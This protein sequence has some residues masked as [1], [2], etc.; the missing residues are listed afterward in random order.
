MRILG[1]RPVVKGECN[2]LGEGESSLLSKNMRPIRYIKDD[3]GKKA[4]LYRSFIL[5]AKQY[6]IDKNIVSVDQNLVL[7]AYKTGRDIL[8]YIG[9]EKRFYCFTTDSIITSCFKTK[10]GRDT[11]LEFPIDLGTVEYA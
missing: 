8:V 4:I 10:R 6:V 1:D 11:M 5:V 2:L 9:D 3:F 7:G